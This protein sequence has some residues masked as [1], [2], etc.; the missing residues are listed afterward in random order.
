MS[1]GPVNP[2]DNSEYIQALVNIVAELRGPGGCPWDKEQNHSTLARYAIEECFEMLEALEEREAF[3]IKMKEKS[4]NENEIKSSDQFISLGEKFKEELGDVLFQVVLHAQLA[5]EEGS[6][7]FNDVV[8]SISEKLV[9]RHPH[10]F[11][12]VKV[13]STA[14]VWKNWE[15]IKKAEKVARGEKAVLISV[16]TGLPALQKALT[17]GEKT[18]KIKFDWEGP[19]EVWLKVEEEFAELQEAM[20]KDVISE[21]E[22]ELG[23]VLFSLAQLARHYELDPEQ[24]LR[25][26]NARFLDRFEKMITAYKSATSKTS[27]LDEVLIQFAVLSTDEKEKFWEIAKKS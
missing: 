5:N 22:H 4:L 24:V 8:S 16:P 23:D 13:T 14:D 2:K 11:G 12:D 25:L 10:V 6:F 15:R 3:R 18:H 17:I 7:N 1:K 26:A 20:D 19:Q 21:I 27:S 9:R